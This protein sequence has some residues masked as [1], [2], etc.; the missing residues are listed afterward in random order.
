ML[1]SKETAGTTDASKS[2]SRGA[3]LAIISLYLLLGTLYAVETPRWQ[4][5][6]EP[7]HY[8]YVRYVA[9]RGCLPEL[10]PGDYPHGL[11]E[12]LKS[13]RFPPEM[14]VDGVLYESHQPP[15]YYVLAACVYRLAAALHWPTLLALRLFSVALG[16]LALWVGYRA[17]VAILPGSRLVALGS[18]AFA[19]TLPMHLTMTA[20]V[21]NDVLVE[22]LLAL[23]VWQLARTAEEGWSI[24]R[25]LGLGVLLGLCLLTKLQAYVALGLA[26]FALV[27]DVRHSRAETEG[28]EWR[29]LLRRGVLVF[30]VALLVALPWLVR[31][32]TLYG[33]GDPLGM[34]RHDQVVL[35]QLTTRAYVEEHGLGPLLRDFALT[36]FRSFWG[37]FGWMGVVLHPRFYLSFL[38]LTGVAGIGLASSAWSLGHRIVR[39]HVALM[40]QRGLA[41][42]G[43]WVALTTASYLWYNATKYL[44]HQGR[45]LFPAILVWGVAFAF[46]MLEALG[47]AT[48]A[49]VAALGVAALGIVTVGLAT[50]DIKRFTLALLVAAIGAL[51]CGHWLE[52]RRRGVGLAM[53]Y[54]GMSVVSVVCLYGYIVPQLSV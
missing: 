8:N 42:L 54:L 16:A 4:V 53:L 21:N 7:A 52:K 45:Y 17:L 29:L 10:L 19:A 3:L 30:G 20:A 27:W 35:G 25:T 47:R 41:L 12:V 39:G 9:E 34:V 43:L 33:L 15:L 6:D 49:C 11:L 23:V 36:T 22:L 50:G 2:P 18:V 32:V 44:Q 5:P 38:L 26:L 24:P 51:L 14:S 13:R 28:G 46:G 40:R 1:P 31:N 37:Q 48:R